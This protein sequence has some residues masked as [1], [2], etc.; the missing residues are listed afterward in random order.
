MSTITA[1]ETLKDVISFPIKLALRFTIPDCR[2]ESMRKWCGLSLMCCVAWIGG[3][4]YVISWMVCIIGTIFS[5]KTRTLS[6]SKIHIFQFA[7]R[8]NFW[9]TGLCK[10]TYFLGSGNI[11]PRGS[12][13]GYCGPS[14]AR[15]YG[16]FQ[17]SGIKYI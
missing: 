11:L 2:V 7:H 14:G 15:V 1:F 5:Y 8:W 10:W 12:F 16:S 4:S 9:N 6:F 17:F 13:F 3:L